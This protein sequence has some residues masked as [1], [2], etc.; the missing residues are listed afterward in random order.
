MN[1]TV[2]FGP[3]GLFAPP[4]KTIEEVREAKRI[5]RETATVILAGMASRDQAFSPTG[6]GVCVN[7]AII[8]AD[9]LLERL[10]E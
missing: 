5:R 7:A 6:V 4:S 9:M 10:G 1:R 3:S 8:L 2:N